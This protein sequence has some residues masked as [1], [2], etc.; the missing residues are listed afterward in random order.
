LPPN[1]R[2]FVLETFNLQPSLT[3]SMYG[4]QEIQ[5]AMPRCQKG[6]RYHV[7]P[8]LICLPLD[9]DGEHILPGFGQG[10]VEGRAAFFDLSVDGRWG[11]IISGDHIHIDY[12][13]CECGARSPSIRDDIRRYAD[14]HGDDKIACSGTV[15]AYVRGLS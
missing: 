7:P 8:W 10:Q 11:G 9:K 3:Y 1:Y 14:I 4:M 6:G 5:T 12:G 15:D 13:T 2:E